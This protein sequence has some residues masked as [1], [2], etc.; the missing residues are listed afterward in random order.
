LPLLANPPAFFNNCSPITIDRM[1]TPQ[2]LSRQAIE[3]F[4]AIY[5]E[6][7]GKALSNDEAQEMALR[8]LRFLETLQSLPP[9][10]GE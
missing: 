3:E 6:E 10:R 2:Q 4:K 1:D 5:R 7:F 9:V 8:L